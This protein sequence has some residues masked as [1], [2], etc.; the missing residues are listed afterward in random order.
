MIVI[1]TDVLIEI[2]DKK[3]PLG[4]AAL[5]RI[6]KSAEPFCI[7][8]LTLHEILYGYVKRS[9]TTG[10]ITDLPVLGYTKEDAMLSASLEAKAEA[11]GRKVA[12]IDSMI[13]AIVINNSA[14]LYTRNTK[15]FGVFDGIRLVL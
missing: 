13:A 7:T 12:R 5:N 9:K 10:E 14:K 1:D 15:D 2:M 6:K 11:K 4:E 3:S 8:S